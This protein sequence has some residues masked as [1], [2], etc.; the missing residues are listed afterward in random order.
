MYPFK[1][2]YVMHNSAFCFQNSAFQPQLLVFPHRRS[3]FFFFFLITKIHVAWT[4]NQNFSGNLISSALIWPL[5]GPSIVAE[6]PD[7]YESKGK[8]AEASA[9][10]LSSLQ[11]AYCSCSYRH[12]IKYINDQPVRRGSYLIFYF[13]FDQTVSQTSG[14]REMHTVHARFQEW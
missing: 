6:N 11:W 5:T 8:T 9:V 14:F 10:Y 12:C 2:V 7:Q 4:E 3:A 13:N 1:W